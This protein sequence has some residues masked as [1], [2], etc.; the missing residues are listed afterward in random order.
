MIIF[1]SVTKEFTESGFTLDNVS[2]QIEKGELVLLTGHSGSG[3]TTLMRLLTR[4]YL[5]T[6]GTINFGDIEVNKLKP[7][8]IPYLRRKIGVVF[9]DYKLL[10]E[11]TVWENIALPLSIVSKPQREIES[12]V[13]DL[14]KLVDLTE[15][16][17]LFPSQ[18]S[19]GEAQRVSIARALAIGPEV[20]FA[21]EP[22]GNLDKNTSLA[23]TRLLHKINELGTTLILATHDSDVLHSL[24]D[25][26]HIHLEKG[27]LVHD[28]G[29]PTS[30]SP[31]PAAAPTPPVDPTESTPEPAP[32]KEVKEKQPTKP[33]TP[34]PKTEASASSVDTD[35]PAG[36]SEADQPTPTTATPEK[37]EPKAV[38]KSKPRFSL[39]LPKFRL[40]F[41][42]KAASSTT[43]AAAESPKSK[44]EV[45]TP[46]SSAPPKTSSSPKS[47][48]VAEPKAKATDTAP[49]SKPKSAVKPPAKP[50]QTETT[51]KTSSTK[52]KP[53]K[54]DVII[55]IETLD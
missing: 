21:D 34:K 14:L 32:A 19:G 38:P 15:R 50:A 28:T 33:A 40:P 55:E 9:Q 4:E 8:L 26:R 25:T 54:D 12:R 23:I 5:P 17:F 52:P 47:E 24:T 31:A 11:L 46:K 53:K 41:G 16:A 27:R 42:K 45:Q 43:P 39:S 10:P 49:A 30:A 36:T 2:F 48:P 44:P 7:S 35:K 1:S 51:S 6:K 3:K 18:L 37:P 20:I 29:R 13:T 22:T